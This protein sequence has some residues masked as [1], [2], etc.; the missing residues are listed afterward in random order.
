MRFI[1]IFVRR[2]VIALVVNLLIILVGVRAA[3]ELPIQQYPRIESSSI[4]VTRLRPAREAAC[5]VSSRAIS[6]NEAGKVSTRSCSA[7]GAVGK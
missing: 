1:D 5:T 2:P 3:Q 4:S 6:S 7:R